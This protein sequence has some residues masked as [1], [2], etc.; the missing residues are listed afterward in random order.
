MKLFIPV[1]FCLVAVT[2]KATTYYVSPNGSNTNGL[3]PATAW[4]SLTS[5]NNFTFSAGD[6][7][8]FKGNTTFSGYL[9]ITQQDA[10]N[11]NL[12]LYFGSFDQG[13]ATILTSNTLN[14]GFKATNV[15][16]V[17]IENLIFQGPGVQTASNK[18]GI[19][20]YSNLASGY[21][22]NI[23]LKNVNV[24]GFGF[25]GIRFYSE[26]SPNVNSGY[27]NVIIDSC[28]VHDCKENGI[29]SIA[30]DAQN[31]TTYQ[32]YGFQ[33]K[34]CRVYNITGYSANNHKGSGI[35]LSQIDSVLIERC[36]V[37]NNGALN[38]ACGGPGGIW[39]YAANGVT[40]QHNES[41][42]NKSGSGN[43]CDGL[44]FDLDGGTTNSIV[45][46]NYSHDN[47]G[48][49][50]LLG[51]FP[52]ARPWGNNVVRYNYSVNDARTNNSP[53][54]LFTAPGTQ[55]NGLRFHNNTVLVTDS[56]NNTYPT[57]SAFQMTDYGT[58]MIGVEC[59]NNIFVTQG[60][61]MIDVPTTFINQNPAFIGNL[62]WSGGGAMTYVYG[63]T[64]NSLSN[65]RSAGVNCE[66]IQNTN[67]G[68]EADPLLPSFQSQAPTLYPQATEMLLAYNL[69]SNTSP[70]MDAAVDVMALF[71]FGAGSKDYYGN[72]VPNDQGPEIGAEEGYFINVGLP[73]LTPSVGIRLVQNP[74]VSTLRI[75]VAPHCIGSDYAV[76]DV[77][78]NEVAKGV[79]QGE[80]EEINIVGFAQGMYVMV[81]ARNS[82]RLKFLK[83]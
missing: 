17:R 12:P 28:V 72:T 60:L 61:P 1:L 29:V 62:Y 40:I 42:H 73:G 65:F 67:Y 10:N 76:L 75:Q 51:N 68:F 4:T 66:H 2:A 70:I 38:T 27:R 15:Q 43:G 31:Y 82:Q 58:Q 14:C 18:D 53:V 7:I 49:G 5:V 30:Y 36:E 24:N 63:N 9:E 48:A 37:F 16:G 13:I 81:V 78:G 21:L 55:W 52:G 45:Q 77:L 50:Y 83:N 35:V 23:R 22:K 32:H 33:I 8:L 80:E 34:K 71:G 25:C 57:F 56:P 74:V 47:D 59:Y 11:F 3:S 20:F 26:W 64:Y 6:S 79:L 69:T 41:H 44:G 39:V 54:T 19:L 46:Y